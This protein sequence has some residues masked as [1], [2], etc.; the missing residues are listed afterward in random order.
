MKMKNYYEQL[1]DLGI[2]DFYITY[3]TGG[4]PNIFTEYRE[5]LEKKE[6]LEQAIDSC[7]DDILWAED[8]P[9]LQL[10]Y[11]DDFMNLKKEFSTLEKEILDFEKD[12]ID[13]VE[14]YE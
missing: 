11:E 1:E 3:D 8:E 12:L 6:I 9:E 7:E 14:S 2:Y 5:L 10:E 13:Y 4:Q